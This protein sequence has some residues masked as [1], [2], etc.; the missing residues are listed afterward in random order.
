MGPAL[1]WPLWIG[2]EVSS[3]SRIEF[4]YVRIWRY[5]AFFPAQKA[6]Y[7]AK[8]SAIE[9]LSLDGFLVYSLTSPEAGQYV[10]DRIAQSPECNR[11]DTI[12][13]EVEAALRE[14]DGHRCCITGSQ[15]NIEPTYIVAPSILH[16]PDFGKEGR[17]RAL[18]EAIISKDG[19]EKLFT[20]L[21]SRSTEKQLQN[22]WFMAPSVR[23]AFRRG[24][25]HIKKS[26]HLEGTHGIVAGLGEDGGWQ[27]ERTSPDLVP[28]HFLEDHPTFYKIPSTKDPRSHP[29]P[30]EFLLTVHHLIPLNLHMF[31]IENLIESG[32]PSVKQGQTG[33]FFLRGLLSVV[34]K[35]IRLA[36][37]SYIER[38]IDYWD[39]KQKGLDKFLPLGLCL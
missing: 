3:P 5:G 11:D 28:L 7:S 13:A 15:K 25:I 16:D 33:R 20:F 35:F 32:W 17:L 29:L 14:R 39:P 38:Q 37:Y 4:N 10:L 21:G 6:I 12:T 26:V 9:H 30:A 2:V 24:N 22:V 18:L 19:V 1:R 23:A 31:C 27:I 8:L 36:L 34:P